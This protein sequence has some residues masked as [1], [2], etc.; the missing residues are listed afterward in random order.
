[1]V[2]AK[3]VLLK[4]LETFL[5]VVAYAAAVATI[6]ASCIDIFSSFSVV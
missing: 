5:E 1:M 3:I 4:T 2:F 6:V